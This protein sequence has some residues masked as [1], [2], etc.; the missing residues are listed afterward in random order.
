[1]IQHSACDKCAFRK[2]ICEVVSE[3]EFQEI[4]NNTEQLTFKKGEIVFKQGTEARYIAYIISGLAKLEYMTTRKMTQIAGLISGPVL[5]GGNYSMSGQKNI[6]S[7]IATI[8]CQVCLI[9]Y[10][11]IR[12]RAMVNPMFGLKIFDMISSAHQRILENQLMLSC[13][14]VPARVAGIL[15]LLSEQIYKSDYFSLPLT[16]RDL[17]YFISCSEENV[18]RTLKSFEVDGII[19]LHGKLI[20]IL[21][22]K[23]LQTVYDVG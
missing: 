9:S 19:E 20:K 4:Y 15:L 3:N 16:R 18:I 1:M 21:D 6:L 12:S 5:I 17:S 22:F 14:R 7:V 2:E 11:V 23:K 13:K 10:Q 8:D